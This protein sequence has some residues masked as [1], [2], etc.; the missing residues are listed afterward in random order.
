MRA[1]L[2]SAIALV[3][4]H[5]FHGP[6]AAETSEDLYTELC[7]SCHGADRYGG[8]GPALLP[9]SLDRLKPE[10]IAATIAEGRPATQMPAF[11]EDLDAQA[12]AALV[13]FVTSAP[14]TP[15]SWTIADIAASRIVRDDTTPLVAAPI[16]GADPLNLFVVVEAG[17][18]HVTLLDG[19]RFVPIARF[20]S[21]FALH[22]GPKFTADGRFVFF[23]SRDG[24]VT[25]YDLWGLEVVAEVRAGLNTRNLAVSE[26]GEI[27]M[28]ANTLPR[29]LVALSG[30]DLAPLAVIPAADRH[31]TAS[32]VSAVYQAAPRASFIVALKDVPELWEIPYG[33]GARPVYSGF[34][35]NWE[36]GMTEGLVEQG[37]FPIRRIALEAPLDDFF[38]TPDYRWLIGASRAAGG[39]Q[40]V[41][42]NVGRVVATVPLPGLPHLGSG[43]AFTYQGRPVLATPN[44][45]EA[46]VSVI[47]TDTWEVIGRVATGGPGFFL[48]GHESSPYVW[49]DQSMGPAPD[50]LLVIDP[51]TLGIV[52]R[53]TPSPGK[54]ANHV[55][56]TRDGRYA[57]VSVSEPAPD[58]ALVVYDAATFQEIA[59]L[60]MNKPVGKYNIFNKI[61]RS[62]GTSH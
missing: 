6:A 36:E 21:R 2:L 59:R 9:E 35:H 4:T 25:K 58:G 18:H 41:N 61:K 5:G 48:R 24:W 62:T 29:T 22:G 47:A 45:G 40:V 57:L 56:F 49:V 60:A 52:T 42:L 19:D 32:R 15:P 12:I 31:G 30:D 33:A 51:A 53:L 50:T 14:P 55:E 46:A 16:Y 1:W 37:P 38:F 54:L 8:T 27:V 13:G 20:P 3:A 28:V 26:D 23:A 7:A 34:V 44:L 43:I 10:R 11:G 17:D 39:A